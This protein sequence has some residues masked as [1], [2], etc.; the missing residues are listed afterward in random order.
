MSATKTHSTATLSSRC[1]RR[2]LHLIE[3]D[4]VIGH[5]WR[6]RHRYRWLTSCVRPPRR[7]ITAT[8]G[9]GHRD[10]PGLARVAVTDMPP[11]PEGTAWAQTPLKMNGFPAGSRRRGPG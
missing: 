7:C 3:I 6:P 2:P 9:T 11:T 10:L 8:A 5:H 1:Q 4:Q